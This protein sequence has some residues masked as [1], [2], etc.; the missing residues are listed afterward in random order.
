MKRNIKD[1]TLFAVAPSV[2][3][4]VLCRYCTACGKRDSRRQ[5]PSTC[6]SVKRFIA[7]LRRESAL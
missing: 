2:L 4:R 1:E 7:Q 3:A 5:H 6:P